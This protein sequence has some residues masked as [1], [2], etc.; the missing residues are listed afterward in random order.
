LG[1]A[2]KV[3]QSKKAFGSGIRAAKK[4]A[5]KLKVIEERGKG[6]DNADDIVNMKRGRL[7]Q[8]E[9]KKDY[10][11]EKLKFK[12]SRK[13]STQRPLPSSAKESNSVQARKSKPQVSKKKNN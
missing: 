13:V 6:D 9:K 10:N 8:P 12:K 4:G 3:E 5:E 2:K 1:P 11:R 7:K